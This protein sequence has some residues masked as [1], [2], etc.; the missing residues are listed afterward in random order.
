[1]ASAPGPGPNPQAAIQK[2]A[3]T[4]GADPAQSA[5]AAII[6]RVEQ[7]LQTGGLLGWLRGQQGE[8]DAKHSS[9][10]SQVQAKHGEFQNEIS[11]NSKDA[12]PDAGSPPKPGPAAHPQVNTPH[13]AGDKGGA[14]GAKAG[15]AGP[16]G[17]KH[18][19]AGKGGGP[20]GKGAAPGG[21]PAA[22]GAQLGGTSNDAQ[23]DGVLNAYAPKSPEPTAML[24]RI[25]QMGDIASGFNGSLDV[26]IAQGGAV[27]QTIATVSNALG[28]GKDVSAVWANNPYAK[29]HGILG[30]VM[31]GLS[32]IKS[33]CSIVG[34]I[35]GKLGM[36]LTVVGLLGM[37]FPPIGTAVS[38]I[39]R[40][41]NVV[42][43]ICDAI[44]FV[45]SAVL[46]GLNGVVLAKQI[47]SGASA[48]E[49]AATADLMITEAND[50]ASGFINMAMVFGP[51]FMKG[52]MGSSK[53]IIASLMKRAKAA[54]GRVTLKLSG[55]VKHFATKIARKLG[56]GGAGARRVGGEWKDVGKLAKAKDWVNNTKLVKAFKSAPATI[57]KVQERLMDRYSK[58][59]SGWAKGM[60]KAE[61]FGV[62]SGAFA[63][64]FD[65]EAKVGAWGEKSGK[66]VGNLGQNTTFGKNMAKAA[67]RSEQQTREA[68]MK[69]GMRDAAHLE[70]ERWKRELR[71]RQRDNPDHIRSKDA[72]KEFIAKQKAKVEGQHQTAFDTSEK[73]R[74]SADKLAE[75][76]Q[77]RVDRHNEEF[78]DNTPGIDGVGSRDRHMNTLNES[79]T[80]RW[81]LETSQ[82]AQDEERKALMKNTKR[83]AEEEARLGALNVELSQL[84]QARKMNKL[85]EKE[86]SGIASGGRPH[87]EYE[88]WHD[89]GSNIWDASA[90]V[91][92]AL[93]VKESDAWWKGA[94][95]TNLRDPLKFDKRSAKGNAAGRG[96]HGIY[97][98]IATEDR[99]NQ[100]A[101]FHNFVQGGKRNSSIGAQT[102]SMLSGI[103]QRAAPAPKQSAPAPTSKPATPAPTTPTPAPTPTAAT[104]PPMMSA[105]TPTASPTPSAAGPA[106]V[107]PQAV[108]GMADTA[109]TP[110]PAEPP[111]APAPSVDAADEGGAEAL[112]YW[113][114]LMPEFDKATHDFGYMRKVAVEFRK[115]QIEGKQKA[116]DTLAIYGRYNEYAKLRKEQAATHQTASQATAKDAQ[117]N[118][119]H[120]GETNASANKGEQKQ[121]EAKGA[122]NDRA[123]VDLPEPE[124]RGFWDRILG[125]LKR[126]AKNKAAQIF[127]WIQE[128]IASLILKGLCGVSM[129]D[130]KDYAGAL[131]RQQGAASGVAQGADAKAGQV[132]QKQIKLAGDASKEAQGAADAIGECD[133]NITDADQFMGDVTTFEQQLQQEK[134][135]AQ[136]FIAQVH[137]A[138][139]AER[140]RL[141]H[142]ADEKAKMDALLAKQQETQQSI[143]MNDTAGAG[144]G[145]GGGSD[146][147]NQSVDPQMSMAPT[148][149]ASQPDAAGPQQDEQG[150]ADHEDHAAADAEAESQ[151]GQLQAA[152]D[153]VAGSG[154]DLVTQLSTK[155]EDY[156]NQFKIALTNHTGKDAQGDR[157]VRNNSFFSDPASRESKSIV[158]AFKEHVEKTKEDMK[159]FGSLASEIRANPSNA[160]QIANTI[161]Q[162]AEH[163]DTSFADSQQHLDEMFERSYL[164]VQ[165]GQRTL[166]SK[167][168]DG[169]DEA[170]GGQE[171]DRS[172]FEHAA[173]TANNVVDPLIAPFKQGPGP[174]PPSASPVQMPPSP[175]T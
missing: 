53:G 102:R 79:R 115:A 64:K 129:G 123:A 62:T 5:D 167:I 70:E 67:E 91:L 161:I 152:A 36:V 142:E 56:F 47:A 33:V 146:D 155:A 135:H 34:S 24:G 4:T 100:Q 171:I 173:P 43:M 93:H 60:R 128:K 7:S 80:K 2:Y 114:S 58:S 119:S 45:L 134:A 156:R 112:P 22:L 157:V 65:I 90:P 140:A 35:C 52:L 10:S 32:A 148:P 49:K 74:L 84:D 174:A 48:E 6:A 41:L 42:G 141:K 44:A 77:G 40:I 117:G 29:V 130:L 51:K 132:Q 19:P 54:I 26:Y 94:E 3:T 17:P 164:A 138:A 78:R 109:K 83:S 30:K 149:D 75:M 88:N 143:L 59:D 150:G 96:G 13:V 12:P 1:M 103:T 106:A 16:A 126:W 69:D 50:T 28:V 85:H 11:K 145:G 166:K 27:E 113:P 23:L 98:E 169:A 61:K 163:L 99:R 25:K 118:A 87:Q 95:K 139:H 165:G 105:P 68:V 162:A 81:E 160:Q 124:S 8:V 97:D 31:Q 73:K 63:E 122:A 104:P 66:W 110:A 108:P 147:Q 57:E 121:G 76:K 127:G 136:S 46:T 175:V 125:A 92:E 107:A 21:M 55:N 137:A 170:V 158:D 18:A 89:V 133:R 20:G 159:G 15:G 82:R 37:I 71:Q 131:R 144:G 151:A 86:I 9:E 153:Y 120:A 111:P 38:G 39:A 154:D 101:D 172:L 72:E 116:V 168:L 14:P